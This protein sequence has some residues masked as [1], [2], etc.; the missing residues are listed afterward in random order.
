MANNNFDFHT[1]EG[2]DAE[3]GSLHEATPDELMNA[4]NEHLG[5][6]RKPSVPEKPSSDGFSLSPK[7]I[8]LML[9]ILALIGISF[10]VLAGLFAF[11]GAMLPKPAFIAIAVALLLAVLAIIIIVIVHLVR[12]LRK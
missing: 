4:L 5:S 2:V 6:R 9:G 7:T 10:P 11:A 1:F 12:K 8:A 3:L